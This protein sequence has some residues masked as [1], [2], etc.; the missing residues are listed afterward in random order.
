MFLLTDS[1]DTMA[2]HLLLTKKFVTSA[3]IITIK[4]M[5]YSIYPPVR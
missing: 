5:N 2:L 4:N 1:L 3:V